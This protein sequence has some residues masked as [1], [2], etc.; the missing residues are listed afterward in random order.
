M[1]DKPSSSSSGSKS[2][3]NPLAKMVSTA[4]LVAAL[5]FIGQIVLTKPDRRPVVACTPVYQ[6]GHFFWLGGYR[7]L[8]PTDHITHIK[9]SRTLGRFQT[10]C[11]AFLDESDLL[12]LGGWHL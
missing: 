8:A 6:A 4:A 12:N 1:A 11:V 3:S 9:I 2:S 10:K 7:I 5:L